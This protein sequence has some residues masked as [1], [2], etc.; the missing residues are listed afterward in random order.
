MVPPPRSSSSLFLLHLAPPRSSSLF[1]QAHESR[2][3]AR[4]SEALDM[5]V[6]YARMSDGSL[7]LNSEGMPIEHRIR[8]G[9]VIRFSTENVEE[10][11][12]CE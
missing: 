9:D 11:I 4:A 3:A 10:I 5:G 6:T 7:E 8:V 2:L 12:P 1:L